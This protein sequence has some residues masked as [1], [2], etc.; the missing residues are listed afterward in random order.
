MQDGALFG[1]VNFISAKH[2]VDVR[3]QPRFLG[4]AEQELDGFVGDAIL[5]VIEEEAGGLDGHPYAALGVVGKELSQ[6]CAANVLVMGL[7]RLPSAPL[8]QFGNS[9][10]QALG[11]ALVAIWVL[12]SFSRSGLLRLRLPADRVASRSTSDGLLQ[13]SA[14]VGDHGHQIVPGLDERLRTLV[15]ELGR[16]SV[17]IDAGLGELRQD[18]LAVTAVGWQHCADFAVIGEGFQRR[19]R[20]GVYG[21]RRGQSFDVQHVGRFRILGPGAGPEEPLRTRAS[22]ESALPTRRIEQPAISLVGA[23]GDGDAELIASGPGTLPATAASQRLTNIEATDA[24]LGLS[25]ASMRAR[26]LA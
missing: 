11:V 22:I 10:A 16:Q 18:L 2:G 6:M 8:G 13:R 19:F 21:E 14:L 23:L 12:P 3:P 24:T 15:L 26:C 5:R 9:G 20:H 4:Q 1:E 7:E 17:D 25:P